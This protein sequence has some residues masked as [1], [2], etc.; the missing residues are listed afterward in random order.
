M[1]QI[2]FVTSAALP[3]L[4]ADDRLAVRALA[5]LGLEAVPAIWD[6][7][8]VD[9][10]RFAAVVVRSPWDYFVRA[11]EFARW[12]DRLEAMRA[13]LW[14][15]AALLRWNMD[16]RY[17]R[18]LERSGVRGVPTHWVDDAAG[19]AAEPLADVMRRR[20]W[21]RAVV[22]PVI[23][24]GAHETWLAAAPDAAMESRFRRLAGGGAMVQPLVEE[25]RTEG[26]WSLLF[27]AGEYSH[28]VLKRPAAGDFRVQEAHGG[29]GTRA[30][31]SADLVDA[32]RGVLARVAGPWLYARVDICRYAGDWALMELEMLEPSLFLGADPGAAARFARAIAALVSAGRR[33]A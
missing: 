2:A 25:I 18:E 4:T 24:G 31:P 26:E 33:A 20:A 12:L 16:K 21:P 1:S 22:K 15:P 14:N 6:D 29:R 11:D 9:W 17:L 28:A 8:A 7:A 19:A 10:M 5:G 3:D 30:E 23:S 27:F 13:P 32:A